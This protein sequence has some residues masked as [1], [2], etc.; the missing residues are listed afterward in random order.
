MP[1]NE[2]FEV[3]PVIERQLD[4]GQIVHT[5]SE[6]TSSKDTSGVYPD[7]KHVARFS[8]DKK[9][10]PETLEGETG[11]LETAEDIVTH[12]IAVDDDPTLSPWTFRMFFVG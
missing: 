1:Q 5:D 2:G 4:D 3:P 8:G 6:K 7:E 9:V 11:P 10:D 12:V